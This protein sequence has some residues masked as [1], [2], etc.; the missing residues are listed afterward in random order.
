[1]KI[2]LPQFL[3]AATLAGAPFAHASGPI[4]PN[5]I[6]DSAGNAVFQ[7]PEFFWQ[8]ELN[9]LARRYRKL[10]PG[11]HAASGLGDAETAGAEKQDFARAIHEHRIAPSDPVR[12]MEQHEA[13]RSFLCEPVEVAA[14]L[15]PGFDSEFRDYQL[16]ALAFRK[17]DLAAAKACFEKLLTRPAAQRQYRTVWAHYMLAR[18]GSAAEVAAHARDLRAAV[19]AGFED[20]IDCYSAMLRLEACQD[21]NLECELMLQTI[22]DGPPDMDRRS[23]SSLFLNT[24]MDELVAWAKMPAMRAITSC[25]LMCAATTADRIISPR[26]KEACRRWNEAISTAGI[27]MVEDADRLAWIAYISGDYS[28]AESWLGRCQN[29]TD[30]SLWLQSKIDLRKGRTTRAIALIKKAAQQQPVEKI[31]KTQ[32]EVSPLAVTAA[33]AAQADLAMMQLSAGNFSE[34]VRCFMQGNHW[35]D[36]AWVAERLMTVNEL[37]T[38]V[39]RE[40]SWDSSKESLCQKIQT[41]DIGESAMMYR[42]NYFLNPEE[43]GSI[44]PYNKYRLRWLLGRRLFREGRRVEAMDFLPARLRPAARALHLHLTQAGQKNRAQ[45]DRALDWWGAAWLERTQGMELMGTE[46]EPDFAVWAG[47]YQEVS[48]SSMRLKSKIETTRWITDPVTAEGKELTAIEPVLLFQSRSELLR[49]N[50]LKQPA[51]L[52]YHYRYIA[53]EHAWNASKL[54]PSGS[55]EMADALNSAGRWSSYSKERQ[56]RAQAFYDAIESRCPQTVLGK[57]ILS[58]K[59]FTTDD[60]PLPR[61]GAN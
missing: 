2:N 13:A 54:F 55:E 56:K 40:I 4:L 8:T 61:S 30:L 58:S 20:S 41:S 34:T 51:N 36:A 29:P 45:K 11:Y 19:E 16:G 9:R 57:K 47:N 48:I 49:L 18:C 17:D 15:P 14:I 5:P 22:A 37:K 26:A 24:P 39:V 60:G 23:R 3:L 6:L 1:M 21:Q 43:I 42:S 25:K 46:M 12:A 33:S 50:S 35:L 53:A 52:R 32:L 38:L 28:L 27:G 44:E 59:N 7:P 31:S 10:R